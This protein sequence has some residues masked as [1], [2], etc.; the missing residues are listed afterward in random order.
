MKRKEIMKDDEAE[1][2]IRNGDDERDDEKSLLVLM[3]L[4]PVMNM[5]IAEL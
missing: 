3:I 1:R 4:R 2:E 5:I